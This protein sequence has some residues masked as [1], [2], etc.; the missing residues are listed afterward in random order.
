MLSPQH[1][2]GTK[3]TR[4]DLNIGFIYYALPFR[5]NSCPI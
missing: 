4:E 1:I 3:L 2:A 5:Y